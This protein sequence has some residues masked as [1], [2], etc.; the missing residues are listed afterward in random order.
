MKRSELRHLIK[1]VIAEVISEGKKLK[2]M[3]KNELKR[4]LLYHKQHVLGVAAGANK[5]T[6]ENWHHVHMIKKIEELLGIA[7]EQRTFPPKTSQP[8]AGGSGS[9]GTSGS[10][11]SSGNVKR[12]GPIDKKNATDLYFKKLLTKYRD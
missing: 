12:R 7:P 4:Q 1:E 3:S 6:I 2:N 8:S 11:G 9:S 5:R 10:S